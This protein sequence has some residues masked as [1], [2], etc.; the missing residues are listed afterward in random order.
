MMITGYSN[1]QSDSTKTKKKL[2][3]KDPEDGA[4]DLSQFLLEANG[5]LPV[6][7]PI[8]E[9]AVGY[10]GGAAILYFHKRKKQYSTYVPP[11][12]SGV[13][14]LYTQNKTWGAGAFHSHIFGENRVR[15][16]T[17]LFKP[18]VRIKY[19]GNGSEFLS[20]NPIGINLDSWVIFQKAELR[21]GKSKFYAGASYTYFKTDVS[22]D[23]IPGRPILNEIIKRLNINSTVSSI[24]PH[25]TYDSRNNAFTPTKGIKG[26][27]AANF[28]AEWLGS[29]DSFS[30]MHTNFYGYLPI[31]SR[32]NSAWR[33]EGSYLLGDAPFY[34][35]P[36]LDLRGIPAM[37]YQGDN[38]MLTET[39]WTYNVYKRWS[40][41]GFVGGGKAFSEFSDFA[42]S[43]WAYTFGTGFRYK[44]ARLLG[45]N[46][47]ADF[48]WGNGEDF[49]FYI[50][51]GSAWF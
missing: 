20:K 12:V 46:M 17:A 50:V 23:T 49:A 30:T 16:I 1:A 11:N 48:A 38:V 43:D 42:E 18:D 26:E 15:T 45:V 28:S 9:P 10:G 40:L 37:R 14:G 25:L 3:F 27:V 13:M 29:S 51:F 4:L 41:I 24:K 39:E 22:F 36:F 47:G 21:L 32:F 33:F 44:I 34:A 7:I 19:Y 35:Y 6:I 2:S 31:S 8:T 5:V